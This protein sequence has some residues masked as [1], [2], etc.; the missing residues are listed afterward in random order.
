ML[1][2][3]LKTIRFCIFTGK[4]EKKQYLLLYNPSGK[5]SG[6]ATSLCTREALVH[7][8]IP[9]IKQKQHLLPTLDYCV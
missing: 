8:S 3:G 1:T 9:T 2:E 4:P 5:T 6:F 7:H